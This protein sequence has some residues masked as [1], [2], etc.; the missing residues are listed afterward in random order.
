MQGIGDPPIPREMLLVS[1]L[2]DC[3]QTSKTH[4]Q[5]SATNPHLSG[6]SDTAVADRNSGRSSAV[7]NSAVVSGTAR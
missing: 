1:S 5:A 2:Q 4:H 3:N 7:G 6:S